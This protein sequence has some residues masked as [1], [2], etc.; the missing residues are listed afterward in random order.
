MVLSAKE[1][2]LN[3]E[4]FLGYIDQYISGDRGE[5]LKKYYESLEDVLLLYPAATKNEYHSAFPGGYVMHV[6][7]VIKA[8]IELYSMWEKFGADVS[9]FTLEELVFSAINHDLGKISI[10][11]KEQ[12]ITQT[13]EWRKN[14]LGEEYAYDSSVYYMAVPDKSIYLL[15]KNSIVMSYNEMLAIK[16]HDGL[17]DKANESY[18]YARP[19]NRI[20]PSINYILHQADIMCARIEFE[21]YYVNKGKKQVE[22]TTPKYNNSEIKSKALTTIKSD[23]L[24]GMIDSL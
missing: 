15:Q 3:W 9:K 1:I 8:S 13:D 6:N 12:Y 18:F 20:Y 16:T 22:K 14:K 2:Q 7:S 11:E 23:T 24:K 21:K 5:K 10:H 17:Y 19:E 4:E